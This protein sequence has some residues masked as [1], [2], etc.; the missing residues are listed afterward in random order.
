MSVQIRTFVPS[1]DGSHTLLL[2]WTLRTVRATNKHKHP[3]S[4]KPFFFFFLNLFIK[5]KYKRVGFFC[6]KSHLIFI[7]YL[8][9]EILYT[10]LNRCPSAAIISCTE[11]QVILILLHYV[12]Q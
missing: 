3:D 10:S 2:E 11:I 8:C 1:F 5:L 7:K 6:M 4:L 9:L 12:A